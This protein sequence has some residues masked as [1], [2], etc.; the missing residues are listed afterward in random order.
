M[1][2]CMDF[3]GEPLRI[4][5]YKMS[6]QYRVMLYCLAKITEDDGC[7]EEVVTFEASTCAIFLSFSVDHLKDLVGLRFCISREGIV[8][9]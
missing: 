5:G 1:D 7:G 6:T 3:V 9:N 4:V 2:N 8:L